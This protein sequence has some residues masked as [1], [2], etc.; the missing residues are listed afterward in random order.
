[1]RFPHSIIRSK[2][3]YLVGQ[4]IICQLLSFVPKELVEESVAEHQSDH[5]YKTMTFFKQFVFLFYG[6]VMRCKS[7]NNL[8]KNLL[9]LEN[10]L[11]YLGITELPAVSTLS[12][13][14]INRSSHVF[15][16]LYPKSS[17]NIIKGH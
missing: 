6:V 11:C 12:D 2:N 7:L 9:L 15:A 17:I 8:C 1:M 10:K 16:T 13:A 5:Y 14:N 3:K 4:P